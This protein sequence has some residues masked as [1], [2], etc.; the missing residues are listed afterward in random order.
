MR[1]VVAL[2]LI[3][4]VVAGGG[5]LWAGRQP[6]PG[7]E[8][9]DPG[10]VVG[11]AS[12][13]AVSVSA[14]QAQLTQLDIV[15]EQNGQATP[16]FSLP[17][18]SESTLTQPDA[19]TMQVSR[20][21]GK[22]AIPSLTEGPA[23][24]RVTATRPLLFG[25]RTATSTLTRELQVRLTPPRAAVL[26]QFHF[27]NHGGSEMVVYRVTPPD[28][29]SGVL[30]GDVRYRG[31]NASD[32]GVPGADPGLKV[33]FFA[34][35]YRQDANTPVSV[36]ARDE[37]GNEST[38][39]VEVKA[40]PKPFRKSRIEVDDAFLSRVVPS[41]AD[42]TQGFTFEK[43]SGD[44]VDRYLEINGALRRFN[45]GQ[46]AALMDKTSPKR[47]WSEAFQQL[48]NSQVEA[49]FADQRT[50]VHK[51]QEID[52]QVHL[53]FD[54]AVTAGVPVT[55]ANAGTVVWAQ[56]LGIYGNCVIVDHGMGVMSLYA[57]LS[58]IGVKEG[59]AVTRGHVLGRSGMTGLAG[60]DHL[61]FTM[62]VGGNAVNPVDWW[63]TQ[64]V[65]DR[66]QRK[67]SAAGQAK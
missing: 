12:T 13:L 65:A 16:V 57:H 50:Y 42:S 26:S 8:V 44:L 36:F 60:G 66:I 48:A 38:T 23:T 62:L 29:S 35:L 22:R 14:P 27:V 49:A 25:Y 28:A 40:F 39:P 33:A 3:V 4:V 51:G 43:Q 9:T 20:P 56:Y 41:I 19:D 30:V 54:L 24:L 1:Y 15:L 67:L 34:L 7:I 61:H 53:G 6:G 5:W 11:Q 21:I 58:E 37:V 47:L 46:I 64:W 45:D 10:A 31:F 55:A 32:A 52:R 2:L 63:S 18:N 59:D 17:G